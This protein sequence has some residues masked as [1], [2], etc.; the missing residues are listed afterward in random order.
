[1]V[2]VSELL[3]EIAPP[4]EI[5]VILKSDTGPLTFTDP[6]GDTVIPFWPVTPP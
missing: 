3:K 4:E 2:N 5:L 1:M 6:R